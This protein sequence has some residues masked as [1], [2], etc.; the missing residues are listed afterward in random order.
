MSCLA[1]RLPAW[2][3]GRRRECLLRQSVGEG[4][5]AFGRDSLRRVCEHVHAR[6]GGDMGRHPLQQRGVQYGR[7]RQ[8]V[9]LHQ[10][11]FDALVRVCEDG[12]GGDLAAGPRRGGNTPQGRVA[13]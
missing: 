13:V 1:S 8:K 4:T 6:V 11:I 10:R 7:L 12:E 3:S 2:A 5:G 9:L